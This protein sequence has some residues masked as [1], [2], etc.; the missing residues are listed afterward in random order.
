MQKH[1]SNSSVNEGTLKTNPAS[2]WF[3]DLTGKKLLHDVTVLGFLL[4]FSLSLFLDLVLQYS[5]GDLNIFTLSEFIPQLVAQNYSNEFMLGALVAGLLFLK[6]NNLAC[7][8]I[9]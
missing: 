2:S 3:F 4:S 1:E 9:L 8:K 6:L 7:R 5:E